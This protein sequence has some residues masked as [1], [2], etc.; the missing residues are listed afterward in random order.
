MRK[1]LPPNFLRIEQ[2]SVEWLQARIGCVTASR[3]KDA[4]GKLKSGKESAARLKYKFEVLTEAL[5][6]RA[7]E[8][9][10]SQAMEFGIANEPIARTMYE[11]TKGV[12]VE[13]VGFVVHP[14]I[15][16][17]GASPDG[18]IGSDG[19]VEIKCPNTNTHLEYLLDGVIPEDYQPQMMFQLA[20]TGFKYCDFVSFDPRLPEEYG[21]FIVRLERDDAEIAKMEAEVV[22]FIGEINEMAKKLL[23]HS[24]PPIPRP[25]GPPKAEM[26]PWP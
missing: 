13:R 10:V 3:I 24:A 22:Q 21:L 12:E 5:T 6:G 9:Y 23:E 7:T 14:S 18:I 26:P 25:E 16:R 17:C 2:Q 11:M 8:H 20:C 19:L 4:L 15:P 1:D